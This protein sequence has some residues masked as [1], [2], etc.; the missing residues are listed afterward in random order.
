MSDAALPDARIRPCTPADA[1]TA[2]L[3]VARAVME[4]LAVANSKA[5]THPLTLALWAGLSTAFMTAMGW[6]PRTDLEGIWHVLGYLR[7]VPAFAVV[8]FPIMLA[9]DWKQRWQFE[10]LSSAR[11]RALDLPDKRDRGAGLFLL[12]FGGRAI[13][14][15]G[16]TRQSD[17]ATLDVLYVDGPFRVSPAYIQDDLLEHALKH[18]F[19]N[20]RDVQR[21]CAR[22][23]PGL[24]SYAYIALRKAGFRPA[25]EQE[26]SDPL[27]LYGW[28]QV[29]MQ[30]T[31]KSWEFETQRQG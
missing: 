20:A 12:E 23:C 9:I 1:P 22:V 8:A 15:A 16:I 24:E 26:Q 30:L 5:Y 2:R 28:L 27:G 19:S 25:R 13:G 7:P 3:F 18:V 6:W 4:Q 17:V 29:G 10:D 11:V 21:V 14:L 31:R